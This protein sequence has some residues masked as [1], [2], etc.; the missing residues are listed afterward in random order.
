MHDD[1]SSFRVSQDLHVDAVRTGDLLVLLGVGEPLLLDSGD[2]EDIG[3]ADHLFEAVCRPERETLLFHPLQDFRRHLERRWADEGEVGA[4]FGE[5]ICERMDRPA[6][7]EVP[8]QDDVLAL[9]RTFLV[10]DRVQVEE[11]LG[12]MLACAVARV[13]DRLLGEVRGEPGRAFVRMAQDD[14]VAVCLDH[15]DRVGEGLAFLDGGPL[16]AAESEGTPAKP[17]HRTFE[18]EPGPRGGVVEK[19][20]EDL[21][22]ERSGPDLAEQVLHPITVHGEPDHPRRPYLRKLS[23]VSDL[24]GRAEPYDDGR[25]AALSTR[26]RRGSEPAGP[27][28]LIAR[29]KEA[30][31]GVLGPACGLWRRGYWV[32][33]CTGRLGSTT[34]TAL[35]SPPKSLLIP[36][37]SWNRTR[38]RP[39]SKKMYAFLSLDM[40]SEMRLPFCVRA[41]SVHRMRPARSSEWILR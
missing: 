8:D 30:G 16:G 38:R 23:T 33:Y 34:S 7:L 3:F 36:V 5:R 37:A 25:L 6:V 1:E 2:V 11:S 13:D 4:E 27:P 29:I 14:G 10:P 12:R 28:L 18:R 31:R 15:A 39:F 19:R 40:Y 22:F 9:E 35:Q 26:P 32:G 41:R 20:R 24:R 17:R 21:A